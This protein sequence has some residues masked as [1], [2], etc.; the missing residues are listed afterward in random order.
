[1]TRWE[2]YLAS[3]G[4]GALRAEAEAWADSRPP[5]IRDL[6]RRFPPGSRV[7]VD[8]RPPAHV[9]GYAEADDGTT[10]LWLTHLSPYDDYDAALA[11]RFYLCAEHVVPAPS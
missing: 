5:A 1:M 2:R 9:I 6:C 7:A 10:G 11:A 8:D 3:L 4:T